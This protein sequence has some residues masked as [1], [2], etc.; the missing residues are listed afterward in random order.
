MNG[1]SDSICHLDQ[2]PTAGDM[3]DLREWAAAEIH[4]ISPR[5]LALEQL[6]NR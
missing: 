5:K 1:R 2:F 4:Q 6:I 3:N